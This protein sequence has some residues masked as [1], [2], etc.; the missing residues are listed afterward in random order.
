MSNIVDKLLMDGSAFS[1]F[2]DIVLHFQKIYG[3]VK[4]PSNYVTFEHSGSSKLIA[5]VIECGTETSGGLVYL[6]E[7]AGPCGPQ[8]LFILSEKDCTTMSESDYREMID[9]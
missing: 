7:H 9:H 6:L 1:S 3:K 5:R 2:V 4:K 8:N